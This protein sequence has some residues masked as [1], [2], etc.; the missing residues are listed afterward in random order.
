MGLKQCSSPVL[1]IKLL[2]PPWGLSLI[3]VH[4]LVSKMLS[5]KSNK[6][7]QVKSSVKW[8]FKACL[9][10]V[11]VLHL[12]C[13][14]LFASHFK[15]LKSWFNPNFLTGKAFVHLDVSPQVRKSSLSQ[16]KV[17]EIWCTKL[18]RIGSLHPVGW[19]GGYSFFL[20]SNQGLVAS[21][22]VKSNWVHNNDHCW[23]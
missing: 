16:F 15:I 4:L 7:F 5:M 12:I 21:V 13:P 6:E 3:F 17:R 20:P 10:T 22:V 18:A 2:W 11:P 23:A 9:Q 14:V 19:C 8:R 1:R